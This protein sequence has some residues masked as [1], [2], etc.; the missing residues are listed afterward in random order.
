MATTTRKKSKRQQVPRGIAHIYATFN[1]TIITITDEEGNTVSQSSPGRCSYKGS[2]KG[3]PY[4]AETAANQAAAL[5]KERGMLSIKVHLKG[6]GSGRDSAVRA[7][8]AHF[9][10]IALI[11]KTT[12]PHN[13]CRPRKRRRA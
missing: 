2:R 5:A 6:P 3:T 10:I 8:D 13:G 12:V 11:E 9:E 4:A 7:L 1:N